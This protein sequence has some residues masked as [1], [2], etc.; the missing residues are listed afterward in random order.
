MN[1]PVAAVLR[2]LLFGLVLGGALLQPAAAQESRSGGDQPI[3]LVRDDERAA[4]RRQLAEP[5]P[6]SGRTADLRR[7]FNVRHEAARRLGDDAQLERVLREA[8]A[9]LPQE[10]RWPNDLAWL[11]LDAGR[12]DEARK[13]FDQAVD[14][15]RDPVQRL[16]QETNRLVAMPPPDLAQGFAV[17]ESLRQRART[18]LETQRP[19]AERIALLRVMGGTARL[20]A[21]LY[22]RQARLAEQLASRAEAERWFR[23]AVDGLAGVPDASRGL[24]VVTTHSLAMA[25]RERALALT[26]LSRFAE[27]EAL[28]AQHL[29]L[30]R[31]HNLP[32]SH[33][34]GAH[35]ALAELRLGQGDLAESERHWRQAMQAMLDLGTRQGHPH[36]LSKVRGLVSVLWARGQ[37]PAA[38]R[39]LADLDEQLRREGTPPGR[40][41]MP[42]ERGLVYLD[43]QRAADA[44]V[45]FQELARI[46]TEVLGPGHF[47]VA[48]AQGL[49]GVALWRSADAA[50]RERG[51][52]QLRTAVLDMMSP[53]HTDYQDDAGLRRPV[54]ELILRTYLEAMAERGGLQAMAA[55]GVADRLLGGATAQAMMDAA[56]RAAANDA[57]LADLVR[58][59]Q[60]LRRQLQALQA[61]G[62][63]HQDD[64]AG[65]R[66]AGELELQHQQLRERIRARYPGYD[67]LL[68]PPMPSPTELAQRLRRDETLLLALPA[69]K[70]LYLWAVSADDLPL[71][72]KVDVGRAE[73]DALVARLR[74]GLDFGLSG[75]KVPRLDLQAAHRLYRLVLQ[76]VAARLRERKHLIMVADGPLARLPMSVALTAPPVAGSEPAWLAREMAVSQVPTVSA[77]LALR[78]LP[79]GRPAPE[80]LMAWADPAF[81]GAG[82]AGAARKPPEAAR[83]TGLAPALRY[84]DLPPLPETRGEV[85]AIAQSLKANADNDIVLGPRATRASV[86]DASRSGVLVRKRVL[87]FATHGLVAGDLPG[88]TQPALA[89]ATPANAQDTLSALI[90]LDDILGLRLNAD[91]VVLSACNTAASDGRAQE[92]LSGLARGFLY[93]G[94]R[95]LLVTHWAVETD[96]ARLL[97]TR[98]FEHQAAQPQASKAESLRQAMLAVMTQPKY[99]QP[100]YWAPFALVGEGAR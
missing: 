26:R 97:T 27:A 98:T 54:R 1:R 16:F 5:E 86:L 70:A 11:L 37:A 44:A 52:D 65:R 38:R 8:M 47:Y 42:F 77:W 68:R 96:S 21:N 71:F 58:Q 25:Q 100:A 9:R 73:L 91:W 35:Q 66:R 30:I 7:Y 60:D 31:R 2:G 13:M 50:S 10:P 14:L 24:V 29:D 22:G 41:R 92:A 40:A 12:R 75:G 74:E 20:D 79:A 81:A 32:A 43:T 49:A 95:S 63:E 84:Q 82:G 39:L 83:G 45:L 34:A 36:Y 99:A 90:G 69:D 93:A 4:L 72:V 18:L 48:Q 6:A 67:Q 46:N 33:A 94:A 89:L 57:G 3:D 62:A 80:P 53:R 87:V 64:D 17:A 78:Q 88:L 28:L 15:A 61:E 59:E 56:L 51:Q 23:E 55:L 85:M 76:P 19:G